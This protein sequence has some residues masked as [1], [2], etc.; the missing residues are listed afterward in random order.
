MKP[1]EAIQVAELAEPRPPAG[2]SRFADPRPGHFPGRGARP[3]HTQKPNEKR[4]P[5]DRKGCRR[6]T[7]EEIKQGA[8][9]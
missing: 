3:N 4:R 5:D 1:P 9:R 2:R 6:M 7:P 8:G